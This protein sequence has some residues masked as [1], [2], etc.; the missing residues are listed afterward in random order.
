MILNVQNLSVSFRSKGGFVK[1]LDNICFSLG[2]GEVLAFAGESGSGK[3]TA[4]NALV[5]LVPWE[6]G[7]VYELFGE[8]INPYKK[9][10]FSSVRSKMQMAFQDPYSSL[11]P[12][13]TVL[14]IVSTPL[15]AHGVSKIES[16]ARAK[17]ILDMV[18]LSNADS[19][20]FPH[21][22]SGGQRQRIGLARSLVLEPKILIC[23]EI[24][25]ALDVSVQAQILHLLNDLRN[26]LS[27]SMIFISHDLAVIDIIANRVMYFA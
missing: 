13:N 9:K 10:S 4:A 17:K 11:N 15:L 23:D 27:L 19:S 22:F 2:K 21:A 1:A 8:N 20:K 7:G 14:E 18:G 26:E 16:H 5:G 24:T 12:R 3:S 25:S 6:P